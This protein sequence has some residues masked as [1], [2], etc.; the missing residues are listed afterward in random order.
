AAVAEVVTATSTRDGMTDRVTRA[1][2]AH[3]TVAA[4]VAELQHRLNAT[5]AVA[6][7][8]G[9]LA[10][11]SESAASAT[12]ALRESLDEHGFADAAA[13]VAA[14][15]DAPAIA[16]IERRIRTAD[17]ARAAATATL[18]DDDI[19]ALPADPVDAAPTAEALA[20]AQVARDDAVG[21][22]AALRERVEQLD[23]LVVSAR[24]RMAAS[25]ALMEEYRQVRELS[26]AIE[27]GETNEKRMRLET[28]VL[29]ARLEEIVAAAN[30]RLRTMTSGR[31]SLEHDDSLQFRGVRSGL[32]LA[33]RDEHSGRSRSTQSLSGGE[34]FLASLALALGLAEVVTNQAGGIRLDTLFVDEGF[35]SLDSETL[36]IAMSTLDSLRSGGRTIGLISHVDAMKEQIAAKLRITVNEHGWSEIDDA[37]SLV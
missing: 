6:D 7:A 35:G 17:D 19:A 27:G 9:I 34:T 1:R 2:G 11:R 21:R 22:S 15:L 12:V 20:A 36:E 8:V 23:H 16:A 32:A 4:R 37:Y 28:Y 14:R 10:D 5:Q 25:T 3:D 26:T 24:T 33:I 18:A 31:Y 29:A 30:A 13:V